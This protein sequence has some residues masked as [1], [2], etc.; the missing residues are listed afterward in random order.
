[1]LAFAV[2]ALTAYWNYSALAAVIATE[3]IFGIGYIFVK[4][5]NKLKE[6]SEE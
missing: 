2:T 3:T 1:L 4:E 5:K 6:P